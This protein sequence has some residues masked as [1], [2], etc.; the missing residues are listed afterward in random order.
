MSVTAKTG[1]TNWIKI[2]DIIMQHAIER[3][4]AAMKHVKT[5]EGDICRCL[6]QTKPNNKELI[7]K[8][9]SGF[10]QR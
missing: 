7:R 8:T 2:V 6:Y 1:I 9:R 4:E 10:S 5:L 3:V